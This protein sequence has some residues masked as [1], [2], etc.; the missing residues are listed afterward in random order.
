MDKVDKVLG[1]KEEWIE[2]GAPAAKW[3]DLAWLSEEDARFWHD[4][5]LVCCFFGFM[6][7]FRP[8][9][10]RTLKAPQFAGS[11]CQVRPWPAQGVRVVLA[12]PL[13]FKHTGPL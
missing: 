3:W 11:P 8:K 5:G 1:T 2:L 4:A 9:V 13:A 12:W 7:P 10:F 6:P